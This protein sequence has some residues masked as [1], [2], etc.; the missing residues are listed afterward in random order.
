MNK[1]AILTCALCLLF[2]HLSRADDWK[3]L[4]KGDTLEGLQIV[5]GEPNSWTVKDGVLSTGGKGGGWILTDKEYSNFELELEFKV[6]KEGN[7]GVY[8]RV[9]KGADPDA[10][11]MEVQILDD[12]APRYA[13]LKPYQ[14]A[15]SLYWTVGAN[16]RVS[17][18][19]GEWQKMHIVLD[20]S[21]L[22]VTLNGTQVVDTNLKNH[23]DLYA[24]HPG[25]ERT[26]G[27]IGLQNETPPVEF[28]NIRVRELP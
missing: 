26:T 27:L 6:S 28:R 22:K 13:N 9:P 20:G 23:K 19:A 18:P 4:L 5:N 17:K 12:A 8:L 11:A 1:N 21:K 15:G 24:A 14:Y 25:L 2:Q 7:S 3:P 10:K 16:P